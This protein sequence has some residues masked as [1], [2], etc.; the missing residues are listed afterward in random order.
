MPGTSARPTITIGT[1]N[2]DCRDSE[3]MAAFYGSLLGWEVKWRDGNF[4]ILGN[5]DG[6]PDISFQPYKNYQPPVWPE[7]PGEQWKMIHLDLSVADLDAAVAHAIACGA[8]LAEYQGK[9]DL[10]VML[11]PAG[12]PFCLCAD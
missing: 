11:D 9:E 10:R 12:H 5:P 2:M 7:E 4:I 8:R 1:Y 6:G 3:E